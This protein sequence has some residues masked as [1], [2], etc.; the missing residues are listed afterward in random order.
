MMIMSKPMHDYEKMRL[1][2]DS[3][4]RLVAGSTLAQA[5]VGGYDVR[6]LGPEA[7]PEPDPRLAGWPHAPGVAAKRLAAQQDRHPVTGQ[8]Q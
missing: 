3:V 5:R 4:G 1:D 6:P 8:F 2:V 7:L